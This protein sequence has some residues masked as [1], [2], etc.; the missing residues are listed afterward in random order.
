MIRQERPGIDSLE[1]LPGNYA[2]GLKLNQTQILRIG[3]LGSFRFKS[4]HYL[5]FG[6]ARGPGGVAA[7]VSR[8][9]RDPQQKRAH[10]H[11]DWL[12]AVARPRLVVWS[13]NLEGRECEWGD[14]LQSHGTRE[15]LGF[16]ASDCRCGGHLLRLDSDTPLQYALSTLKDSYPGGVGQVILD[17]PMGD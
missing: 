13:H 6:S 9:L 17:I 2:L 3:R 7:R 5:Y 14:L 8:H 11:I 1:S 15:P 16:G 4:G 10:W 12:S